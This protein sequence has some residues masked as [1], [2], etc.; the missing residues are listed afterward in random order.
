MKLVQSWPHLDQLFN[1][2]SDDAEDTRC[3]LFW[4][5]ILNSKKTNGFRLTVVVCMA[6]YYDLLQYC[7][8]LCIITYCSSVY[9]Y[10]L[11]YLD[12]PIIQGFCTA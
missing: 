10:V 5:V 3:M 9:G 1:S 6:M 4:E 11:W 12:Y 7:V 2:Q 8:W